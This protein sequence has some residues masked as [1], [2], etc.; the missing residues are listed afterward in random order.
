M[1]APIAFKGRTLSV[2][3]LQLQHSESSVIADGLRAEVEKAP[4]LFAQLPVLIDP[5]LHDADL[6]AV[7]QAARDSG[8]APLAVLDPEARYAEAAAAAG[9]GVVTQLGGRSA[10]AATEQKPAAATTAEST[11]ARAAARVVTQN[12]RGGQRLYA[13]GTDLVIC[14]TV[15]PG[16][17]VMA[18]GHVHVYGALRGRA[19]AGCQGDADARIFCQQLDAELLAIAGHYRVA[20]DIDSTHRD[21][22]ALIRLE[23][24]TETDSTQLLIEGLA[25]V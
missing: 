10:R 17:E 9:L 19:L 6:G 21:H 5:N 14:G 4:Q 7:A 13:R 18:D 25:S 16:A 2:T 22:P 8:L 3:V 15:S 11:T 1:S 12:V 24:D 20:E 23:V